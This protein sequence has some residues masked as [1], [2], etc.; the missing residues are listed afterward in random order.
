MQATAVLPMT[1]SEQARRRQLVATKRQ[2]TAL[3][4]G[5]SAVFVVVTVWGTGPAWA[6]Y[7]Q[8]TAAASMVGGLAD[9]FA[10]TALFRHP[11]GLP[12]PHTAIVVERKD[13]FAATL[14]E[15]IQG[16]F[17]TPEVL[18]ARVR[19]TNVVDQL[20]AWLSEPANASR[21]AAE[22]ADAVVAVAGL[23]RDEEVHQAIE[24][25]ARQR[26]EAVRLAPL[27][28]RALRLLTADGRADELVDQALRELSRYLDQHRDDLR[29]NL[30][31]KSRWWLPGAVDHKLFDRV[32]DGVTSVLSDMAADR[33][34]ELRR[35]LD[36]RVTALATQLET[37]PALAERAERLKH[38]LMARPEVQ[39][40]AARLWTDTKDSLRL[41][42]SDPASTV[43]L[44]LTEMIAGIGHRLQEDPALA[45]KIQSGLE[46]V[47]CYVAEHFRG[48]IAGVVTGTVA[49]WD[50]EETAT[51]L[52]LLLGPDLQYV[53]INGTV[54][55][56]GAGLLLHVLAR[57][58]G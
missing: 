5:V 19:A 8:A 15:F 11:L 24:G 36:A 53:R 1:H 20:A 43:R 21:V 7:V 47:L 50:A 2:A 40:W 37:S 26:I 22:L 23:L 30:G 4:A 28:G 32:I 45:T 52:E 13:Q 33:N 12:I 46:S 44:R 49:R 29:R 14:G 35:E 6:D 41:Q 3:L 27:A 10:V 56:A 17:L 18:V 25:V 57:A 16:S 34:H 58:L 55:G 54:V 38:D 42:A 31:R 9:W 39:Q 51:R 48:A